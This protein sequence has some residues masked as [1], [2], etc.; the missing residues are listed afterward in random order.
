MLG[1][2]VFFF[3]VVLSH[4]MAAALVEDSRVVEGL[5]YDQANLQK[6]SVCARSMRGGQIPLHGSLAIEFVPH[7][8]DHHKF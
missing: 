2:H 3:G 4:S 1:F 5:R 8:I 7:Y 6:H